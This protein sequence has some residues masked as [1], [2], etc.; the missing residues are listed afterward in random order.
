MNIIHS[1]AHNK[2]RYTPIYHF[3]TT[4]NILRATSIPQV[5]YICSGAE[6][7]RSERWDHW[8]GHQ[9]TDDVWLSP[10]I[11]PMPMKKRNYSKFT[12]RLR[13]VFLRKFPL[14]HQCFV[15][16]SQTLFINIILVI[17]WALAWKT[18]SEA[19]WCP[20]Q[21]GRLWSLRAGAGALQSPLGVQ[22]LAWP[23]SQAQCWTP[24]T[25]HSG[26]GAREHAAGEMTHVLW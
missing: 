2:P 14:V 23:P 10:V 19:R 9:L 22:T 26:G 21:L 6:V 4:I 13:L 24:H 1:Y 12:S 17:C 18:W 16:L 3:H 11:H 5:T 7:F 15:S 8:P 25:G 20:A